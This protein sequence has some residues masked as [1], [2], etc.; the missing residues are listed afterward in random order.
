MNEERVGLDCS[1]LC[2]VTL[3]DT[4]SFFRMQRETLDY[5]GA[6]GV[7]KL[8]FQ[9]RHLFLSKQPSFSSFHRIS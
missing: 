6:Q 4:Q 1:D 9:I 8:Y 2:K 5:P 3:E 7:G